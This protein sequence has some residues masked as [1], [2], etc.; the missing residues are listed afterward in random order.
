MPITFGSVGDII[1]V[2]LLIKNLVKCF[3]E[4]HGSSSEYQAVVRELQSLEYTLL[5]VGLIFSSGQESIEL[6]ALRTTALRIVAQCRQCITSFQQQVKKYQKGLS[7][8]GSGNFVKDA[9]LKLKWNSG[10]KAYLDK[11]R[12]EITAHHLSINTLVATA[13]I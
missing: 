13:G 6:G 1:T 2:G 7:P 3:D 8:Q 4:A 12:T 9:A 11:F 10:E 5:Q